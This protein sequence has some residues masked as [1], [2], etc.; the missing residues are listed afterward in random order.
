MKK[1][2]LSIGGMTCSACSSGLEKYL[3]KKEGIKKAT[4]NLVLSIASIEYEGLNK[5]EIE[6]FI[7]EAGF[8]SLGEFKKIEDKES[9]SSDKTKLILL[10]GL[11]ILLMYSSMHHLLFLPQIPYIN[12]NH[13]VLLSTIMFSITLLFLIYGRDILKSGIKNLIHRMPNMDTLVMLSVLTSFFYSLEGYLK[14]LNGTHINLEN[15]YFESTCMI[16]YFIKLGRFIEHKSQDKTKEAIKK[17]VQITPQQAIL[18]LKNQEKNVPIDEVKINDLLLARAGDKIAVDGE[19]VKGKTYVDE[20]FITGESLPVLKKEKSPVIAGSIIYDGY[21]EY[22][23]KKIGRDSTI[24]HIVELVVEA[25]NS[26]NKIA[27]LA[28]KLSGYFVPTILFLALALFLIQL[29]IGYPFE[30]ALINMVT[31]L[32][33]ACP[34]ALGL[35]V[36]LVVVVSNGHCAEKGLFVRNSETLEKAKEIDTVVFDKTGTLTYGKLKRFKT[37]NYSNKTEEELLNLVA[38]I[39]Y[40]SNH[41]IATAFKIT[42]KVEVKDIQTLTGIGIVGKIDQKKI[43]LGNEKL[44]KKLNLAPNENK[45]YEFLVEKGCS[46]LYVVEEKQIL[47]LIGV[48]D[49]IR[50][51]IKKTIQAFKENKIEV[52]MLTGDNERTAKQIANE[53]GITNVIANVLPN[54][55]SQQIDQLIKEGKK[56]LMVGDGINDAPALVKATIGVSINDGTDVAMDASS[57]I[58]MNNNLSNLLDLI[59]ISKRSYKI[60]KQNL[61]W[62]F[63]YNLCMLPIASGFFKKYGLMMTPMFGSLAMTLSSLTVV[64]NSLKLER[65]KK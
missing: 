42:K 64:F 28:D 21:I 22:K 49:V 62:A 24:S 6:R 51:H 41:P 36:P 53:V 56:V 43:Y 39:E 2:V 38:N 55:K 27:K 7:K 5:K 45:D 15:L 29:L 37:F 11:I 58:L 14:L 46:I 10:G 19:V 13:P 65:R 4:V 20:S 54:E 18:K 1:I 8:I 12:R 47:G 34:C 33:V 59:K 9:Q 52:I 30:E 3:T 50:P 63:F 32:V 48:R 23:A 31:M 61:F 57:V 40:Y 35:A 16:L 60:I 26:K 17:L 25:T 44:L